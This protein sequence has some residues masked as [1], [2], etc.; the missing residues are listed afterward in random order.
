MRNVRKIPFPN[1]GGP[2][3]TADNPRV[4]TGAVQFGEDWPGH[5]IRGDDAFNLCLQI[6]IIEAELAGNPRARMSLAELISLRDN[7][8]ENTFVGN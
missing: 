2:N 7:I 4:E 1:S 8:R 3:P 6:D 5:F